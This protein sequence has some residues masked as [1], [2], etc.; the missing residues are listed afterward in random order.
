MGVTNVV[1]AAHP[2]V[3]TEAL[4]FHG[5]ERRLINVGTRNVPARREAGLVESQR[6]LGIGNDAIAVTDHEVAGGLA[7]VDAMVTIRGMT[8]D[9][10]VFFV[11]CVHGRPGKGHP[12]LQ[13][14]G[15]VR[16]LDMLPRS[17]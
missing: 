1:I 9:S 3:R 4:V 10:F 16:Q 5:S 8:H 11:E 2:F 17:S 12:S 15:V 13:F 7:D 6:S 14:S